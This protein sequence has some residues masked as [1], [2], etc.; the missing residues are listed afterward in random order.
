VLPKASGPTLY[1]LASFHLCSQ[2]T[3]PSP[4]VS[5]NPVPEIQGRDFRG[6]FA[7]VARPVFP[8]KHY[9]NHTKHDKEPTKTFEERAELPIEARDASVDFAAQNAANEYFP[10]DEN[11]D[12][13]TKKP[14]PTGKKTK[15][16][17]PTGKPSDD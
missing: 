15:K 6:R 4:T 11:D 14:H 7:P 1:R 17:H 3:S 10:R 13:K 5:A 2:L 9:D 12:K 16:P 8:R